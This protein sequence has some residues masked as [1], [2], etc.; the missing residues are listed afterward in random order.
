MLGFAIPVFV[1]GYV[2]ICVFSI[3]LRWLPVQG[4]QPLADGVWPSAS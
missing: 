2:L 3:Q 1:A 4:F